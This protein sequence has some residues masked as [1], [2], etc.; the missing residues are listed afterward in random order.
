MTFQEIGISI[1]TINGLKDMNINN[2]TLVQEKAIPLILKGQNIIVQSKTGTGKTLAYIIPIIE[3][4]KFIKNECLIIA[5][6]RELTKQ[7]YQVI[8]D[9][10]FEL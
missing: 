5:P 1:N 9:L 6:T 10:G 8:K 2:P 7:I 4:M 3:N